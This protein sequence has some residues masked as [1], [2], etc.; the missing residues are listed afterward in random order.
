M[1]RDILFECEEIILL[2][3]NSFHISS[4]KIVLSK[5]QTGSRNITERKRMKMAEEGEKNGKLKEQKNA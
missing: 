1:W 3:E 2:N 5:I 4:I